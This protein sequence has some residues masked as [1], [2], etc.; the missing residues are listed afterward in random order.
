MRA[1]LQ[2]CHL[3]SL[4]ASLLQRGCHPN[5]SPGISLCKLPAGT[6]SQSLKEGETQSQHLVAL[7]AARRGS[8]LTCQPHHGPLQGVCLA[9]HRTSRQGTE[10]DTQEARHTCLVNVHSQLLAGPVPFIPSSFP[11][12]SPLD[13]VVFTSPFLLLKS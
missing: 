11:P 1:G 4:A 12:S 8:L 5:T 10:A 7:L 2:K 13:T 6:I 3:G 9:H